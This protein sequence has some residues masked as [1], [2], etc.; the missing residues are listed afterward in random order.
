MVF[1]AF[2]IV[3][4]IMIMGVPA[5]IMIMDP[6]VMMIV[7]AGAESQRDED[8]SQVLDNFGVH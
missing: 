5:V 1:F 7:I 6:V 8:R 4:V 3:A 2:V